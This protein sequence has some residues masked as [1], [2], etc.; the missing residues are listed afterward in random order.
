MKTATTFIFLVI[1]SLT[2][3]Q[4][5]F[6]HNKIVINEG[7][8]SK[9]GVFLNLSEYVI[10]YSD[11]SPDELYKKAMLWLSNNFKR[12]EY[13]ILMEKKGESFTFQANTKEI[14]KTHTLITSTENY[15]GYKYTVELIFKYGRFMFK[16][17]KLKTYTKDE[18]LSSGWREQMFSNAI[19]DYYGKEIASGQKDAETQVIFF[20]NLADNLKLSIDGG[21]IKNEDW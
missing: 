2:F 17:V 18:S 8:K 6:N 12:G 15:Q 5:S 13:E 16:P 20:N 11:G 3:S 1:T 10:K 7:L 19:E 9:Q 14:L 4:E 21:I